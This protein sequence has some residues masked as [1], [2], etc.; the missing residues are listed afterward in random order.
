MTVSPWKISSPSFAVNYYGEENYNQHNPNQFERSQWHGRGAELLG[1]QGR[2]DVNTLT[3][4]MKGET[5][6]GRCIGQRSNQSLQRA[7]RMKHAPG[8]DLTFAPPKDVSLLYHL[9]NDERVVVAHASAVNKSLDWIERNI[10]APRGTTEERTQLDENRKLVIANFNHD[11]SRDNDPHIHTHALVA[12]MVYSDD[13]WSALHSYYLFGSRAIIGFIY[14]S[15]LKQSLRDIGYSISLDP[16]KNN[17][18]YLSGIARHARDLFSSRNSE[19]TEALS[20][21]E[22][23]NHKLR[24]RAHYETRQPKSQTPADEMQRSWRERCTER[25]FGIESLCDLARLR[26]AKHLYDGPFMSDSY[27]GK[28]RP[29]NQESCARKYFRPTAN[30]ETVDQDAYSPQHPCTEREYAARSAVSFAIRRRELAGETFSIL[31]TLKTACKIA[32]DGLAIEDIEKQVHELIE[33]NKDRFEY[34]RDFRTLRT[35]NMV[36]EKI[37]FKPF[38]ERSGENLLPEN[39]KRRRFPYYNSRLTPQQET[40]IH[41]ILS[42]KNLLV[43]IEGYPGSG[44]IADAERASQ[45]PKNIIEAMDDKKTSVIGVMTCRSIDPELKKIPNFLQFETPKFNTFA[46]SNQAQLVE[47]PIILVDV[48]NIGG[49]SLLEGTLKDCMKLNPARIVLFDNLNLSKLST[50]RRHAYSLVKEAGI[51]VAKV[52]DIDRVKEICEQLDIS[53]AHLRSNM[54][55]IAATIQEYSSI[56]S[57]A[58]DI[59]DEFRRTQSAKVRETQRSPGYNPHRKEDISISKNDE[60]GHTTYSAGSKPSNHVGTES[61]QS[62]S[63]TISS[64]TIVSQHIPNAVPNQNLGTPSELLNDMRLGRCCIIVP[65]DQLRNRLT[66][67]IRQEL[68][69]R[70]ELGADAIFINRDASSPSIPADITG[71]GEQEDLSATTVSENVGTS[72]NTVN[73]SISAVYSDAVVSHPESGTTSQDE[74]ISFASI[75]KSSKSKE[76][77]HVEKQQSC[78]SVDGSEPSKS[79]DETTMP[80]KESTS[81]SFAM[82]PVS[83]VVKEEQAILENDRKLTIPESGENLADSSLTS[84]LDN[85]NQSSPEQPGTLEEE[86]AILGN[87]R[88]V[89]IP[90]SGESLAKSSLTSELDYSTQSTPDQSDALKEERAILGNDREA[91]IPDSGESLATSN[92]TSELDNSTRSSPDQRYALKEERAILEN[93]REV[94]IPDRGES[95]AKSGFASQLDGYTQ[96]S[97]EQP[98]LPAEDSHI[99]ASPAPLEV[100]LFDKLQLMDTQTTDRNDPEPPYMEAMLVGFTD[101]SIS[102][103]VGKTQRVF[104]QDD[105]MLKTLEYSYAKQTIETDAS[106]IEQVFLVVES[107]KD[108]TPEELKILM[109]L[110]DSEAPISIIVDDRDRLAGNLEKHTSIPVKLPNLEVGMLSKYQQEDT[111]VGNDLQKEVDS[112]QSSY[113][114]VQEH[115]KVSGT[116]PQASDRPIDFDME[117]SR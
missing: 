91:M 17:A 112:D 3:R 1:L 65:N 27:G 108:I 11:M 60:D 45:L 102:I 33:E 37:K 20:K 15:Y 10:A 31:A 106:K 78:K 34:D 97:P 26:T 13:R 35:P 51:E 84:E 115:L 99:P 24:S 9:G 72:N 64:E 36:P 67:E 6:D 23:Y 74:G 96:S 103:L 49:T 86:R 76:R 117:L 73:P 54:R 101:K 77:H 100:R 71:H 19:I 14:D 32:S 81:P 80:A 107:D 109:N 12:N 57:C 53:V 39:L 87:D 44:D 5:L 22:F 40:A 18:W 28:R 4:I 110:A 41:T 62:K 29:A 16:K 8:I 83:G 111:I 30:A 25:E 52:N 116:L 98:V 43:G 48:T 82:S 85:S 46:N 104:Q 2:V 79:S 89:M 95:L 63:T 93:D 94:T 42:S 61:N 47:N 70:G 7:L 50:T 69:D 55:R 114:S 68:I 92:L 105:P 21:S 75:F 59:L 56:Q 90:E 66:H 38:V 58:R 113:S 88:E